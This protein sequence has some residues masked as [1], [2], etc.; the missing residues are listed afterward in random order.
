MTNGIDSGVALPAGHVAVV[1][2]IY[3]GL[4][5]GPISQ[6]LKCL[7]AVKLS[8]ELKKSGLVSVPVCRLCGVAPPGFLPWEICLVDRDSKLHYLKS[9]A[10]ETDIERIIPDGDGET[11]SALKDVFT[12]GA[13][14]V[15]SCARWFEYLLKDFG[16]LVT[17]EGAA[18]PGQ[19]S[20][21]ESRFLR[22]SRELF[23]AAFIADSTEI[24]EYAKALP[25]WEIGGLPRPLV[26]PCPD[27]TI[28]NARSL[29]TLKRY[30]LDVE[31]LFEG[32]E[33]VIDCVRETMKSDVPGVLQKL[34][35]EAIAVLDDL[36]TAV[37]AARAERSDRVRKTRAARIACQLDKIQRHSRAALADKEKAAEN[38]IRKACNF[39]APF[40][41]RQQDILC[42][43]QIPVFYGRAG[44]RALFERLDITTRDPQLIEL[45]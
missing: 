23:V 22:Q 19:D 18:A 44:L 32:K 33:R 8:G 10:S 15:A 40:G 36:E 35:N 38:R 9:D 25:L 17:A 16:M 45:N 7:A 34:R 28:S 39:L 6:L 14:F 13:D 3:A 2:N 1:A 5:G 21:A 26:W 4:F 42:A 29:R 11:L 24:A 27:A 37:F 41:R 43:A 30:G 31:R 20:G 12:P